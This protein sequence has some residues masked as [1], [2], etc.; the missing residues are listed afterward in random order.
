MLYSHVFFYHPPVIPPILC[1][2]PILSPY[3]I[4]F[5]VTIPCH[6]PILS[7]PSQAASIFILYVTVI[8]VNMGHSDWYC[9]WL[10]VVDSCLSVKIITFENLFQIA[11]TDIVE[12]KQRHLCIFSLG[13]SLIKTPWETN[14]EYTAECVNLLRTIT[15]FFFYLQIITFICEQFFQT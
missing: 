6:H 2:Q 8:P 13:L 7:I 4:S 11:L 14:K 9:T 10:D 12:K 3:S 1:Y 5:H 15:F